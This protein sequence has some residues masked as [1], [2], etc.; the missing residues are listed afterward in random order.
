MIADEQYIGVIYCGTDDDTGMTL[1][2]TATVTLTGMAL[3]RC[4]QE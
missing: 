3:N 4:N 1:T 2:V